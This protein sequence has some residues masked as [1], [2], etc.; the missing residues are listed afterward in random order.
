VHE[1]ERERE[2]DLPHQSC[3]VLIEHVVEVEVESESESE[4]EKARR[5]APGSS[6]QSMKGV[7]IGRQAGLSKLS[8]FA[9]VDLDT[10]IMQWV[11]I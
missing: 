5:Q 7:A 9:I 1:H 10:S 4:D 11:M 3:G 8:S 6:D 2:R